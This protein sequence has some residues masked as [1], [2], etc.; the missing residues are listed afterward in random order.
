MRRE[1][2]QELRQPGSIRKAILPHERAWAST[3]RSPRLAC[4]QAKVVQQTCVR[5]Q[6]MAAG[7]A[8][9]A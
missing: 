3:G 4:S 9:V 1:G 7:A 5:R 2:A 6:K 8:C